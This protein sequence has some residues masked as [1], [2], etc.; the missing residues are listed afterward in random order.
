VT[1][2]DWVSRTFAVWHRYDGKSKTELF[3]TALIV[4]NDLTIFDPIALPEKPRQE[5]ESF[6]IIDRIVISNANHMRATEVFAEPE[7][8]VVFVPAELSAQFSNSH[9]LSDGLELGPVRATQIE[10]AAAGEFAFYHPDNGG[11]L[12]MGDALINFDPHG[13]TLLPKKYCIDQKQMIRSLRK[14]LDFEFTR[15]FFA[16]GNPIMLRGHDRLAALLNT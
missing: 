1:D 6:G 4:Q 2:F 8:A 7:S 10:G 16:H 13:F 3:S 9:T 15:I 14:L 11:T 12:I 5:F